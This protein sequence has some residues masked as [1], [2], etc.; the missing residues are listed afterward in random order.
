MTDPKRARCFDK[1]WKYVPSGETDISRT[2]RR[3]KR[4]L[5]EAAKAKPANVKALPKKEPKRG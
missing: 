5:A 4:E 1:G 2:F 3:V